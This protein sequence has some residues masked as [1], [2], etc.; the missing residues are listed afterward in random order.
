MYRIAQARAG[1]C[2]SK[3]YE[4]AHTKL[5]WECVEKHKW[6]AEPNNVKRGSWFPQCDAKKWGEKK[7]LTINEMYH[8]AQ[9]PAGKCLSKSYENAHTKLL[10]ECAEKHQWSATPAN[11]KYTGRWCPKCGGSERLTIAEIHRI[12]QARGGKCLSESYINNKIKLLW[13]CFL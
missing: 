7:T 3:S 2:L 6:E 9:A 4:N 11:I 1:K 5:L 13:A 12:A 8:L 10:W